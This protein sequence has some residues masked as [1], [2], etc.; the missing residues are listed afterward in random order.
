MITCHKQHLF[1]R[2]AERGY[3][4]SDVMP[5]VVS[6]QGDEWTIDETHSAYPKPRKVAP[7]KPEVYG[8][9]KPPPPRGA[10]TAM[11]GMLK[12]I[13]IT[14]SPTCKC[15]ARAREMDLKGLQWCRDNVELISTWLGEEATKRKLPYVELAGKTL[16]RLAIR[17]AASWPE[18]VP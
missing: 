2:C 11:K 1:D 17:Q 15:N 10:G 16:I 3:K 18:A 9:P 6:K 5:C 8:P 4:V 13:G 7:A 12:R 14:S